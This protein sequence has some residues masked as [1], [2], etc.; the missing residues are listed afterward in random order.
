M[1]ET[2]S[3]CFSTLTVR[4]RSTSSER[5]IW[6]SISLS[7]AGGQF[8]VHQR[9]VGLPVLLDPVGEGLQ[10]PVLDPADRSAIRGDDAL[11]VFHKRID[12]LLRQILPGKKHM[13]VKSHCSLPFV[14]RPCPVPAAKASATSLDPSQLDRRRKAHVRDGRERRHGRRKHFRLHAGMLR[15]PPAL[16]SA[17]SRTGR[18]RR[19]IQ[20]KGGNGNPVGDVRQTPA[21]FGRLGKKRF[22]VRCLPNMMSYCSRR[23]SLISGSISSAATSRASRPVGAISTWRS[24]TSIP[25]VHAAEEA[26]VVGMLDAGRLEHL[27]RQEGRADRADILRPD[28]S[29]STRRPAASRDAGHAPLGGSRRCRHRLLQ[30]AGLR[31]DRFERRQMVAEEGDD[32]LAG[33]ASSAQS[34]SR[35]RPRSAS[36]MPSA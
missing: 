17:P 29:C 7:A 6:R 8:E 5:P 31:I 20:G 28:R 10:S 15:K 32:R 9:V 26:G 1:A 35:F 33:R 18:L 22:T 11:V 16:R 36:A 14:S 25:G 19:L 2:P 30:E 27:Q 3:S 13:F 4:K 34:I 21:G 23:K 24:M 12:L